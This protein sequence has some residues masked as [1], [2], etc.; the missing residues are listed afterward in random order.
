[1]EVLNSIVSFLGKEV[2][3]HAKEMAQASRDLGRHKQA[4]EIALKEAARG[5]NRD[6]IIRNHAY[7]IKQLEELIK[8]KS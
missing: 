6:T 3:T 4:L 7:A 2:S 8:K 1:M 5:H